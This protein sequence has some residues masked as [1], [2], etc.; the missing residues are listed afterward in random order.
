MH[1]SALRKI[2]T[3]ILVSLLVALGRP[4]PAGACAVCFGGEGGD[5]NIGFLLGTVLMLALPPAVVVGAGVSI[6]RA[7]KRQ[8]ARLRERDAQRDLQPEAR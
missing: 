1:R 4:E 7:M 5:W 3:P 2:A 8:E 6:Y